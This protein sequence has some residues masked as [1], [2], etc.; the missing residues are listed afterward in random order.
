MNKFK[1]YE[2]FKKSLKKKDKR[3]LRD[4]IFFLRT[5]MTATLTIS[6]TENYEDWLDNN[7]WAEFYEMIMQICDE[8]LLSNDSVFLTYIKL[9]IK[10]E[11][12]DDYFDT[13]YDT[14]YDW[15]FM[16]LAREE[17]DRKI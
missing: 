8:I 12:E 13:H 5:A 4:D 10:G 1:Q 15:Y 14:C 16:D 3:K 7:G 17:L 11:A 6:A 9:E 2:K